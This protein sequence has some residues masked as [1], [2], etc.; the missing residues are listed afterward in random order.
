MNLLK[1]KELLLDSF[2]LLNKCI[3]T[4]NQNDKADIVLD[5]M[6]LASKVLNNSIEQTNKTMFYNDNNFLRK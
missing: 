3:N 6:K 4:P 1:N 5:T 2:D